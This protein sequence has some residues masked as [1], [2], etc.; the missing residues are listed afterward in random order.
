MSVSVESTGSERPDQDG[1]S[2]QAELL[3]ELVALFLV[4]GYAH[5]RMGALATRLQCSRTTLYSIAPSKD[6]LV[7]LVMVTIAKRWVADSLAAAEPLPTGA[8]RVVRYAQVMAASKATSSAQLW[9]DARAVTATSDLIDQW[10]EVSQV[11][12][13]RYLQEGAADGSVRELNTAFIATVIQ[14]A[15]Q[16]THDPAQL[17][18]LGLSSGEAML[19]LAR[20]IRT[21]LSGSAN[22]ERP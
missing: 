10:T 8:E 9:K 20:F 12:F 6:A 4:E 1:L 17:E 22:G 14:F 5:L 11:N 16:L 2:R 13:R 19:E 21:G 18:R 15:A 3:E 7:E